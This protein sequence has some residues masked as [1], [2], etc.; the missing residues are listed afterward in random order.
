MANVQT[1]GE[2]VILPVQPSEAGAI[3]RAENVSRIY[4]VGG[5]NV[6]AVR[7]FDW[8]PGPANEWRDFS[9]WK[10]DC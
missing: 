6:A 4:R 2:N 3:V 10:A 1:Q 5:N 7:E 8:R 9:L